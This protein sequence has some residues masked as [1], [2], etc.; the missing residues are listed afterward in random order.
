MTTNITVL[1]TTRVFIDIVFKL[2]DLSQVIMYDRDTRFTSNFWQVLFKLLNTQLAMSIAFHPQTNEQ[3]ERTNRTLEQ[4]LRNYI[5]YCQDDWDQH[6][7]TAEFAYNNAQ[8]S[9]TGHSPFFL[10]H[11]HH[12]IVPAN[13]HKSPVP[14]AEDF[15]LQM[16]NL[17]KIAQD[18]IS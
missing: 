8:Q 1:E 12:S 2:Y 7:A 9:S 14:T 6:L 10:N 18:N 11:G 4:I 13:V 5:S 16:K 15:T 17:L 3:T